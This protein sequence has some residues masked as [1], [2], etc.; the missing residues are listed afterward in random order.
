MNTSQPT[1]PDRKNPYQSPQTTDGYGAEAAE[2]GIWHATD[3]K[4][5]ML[6]RLVVTWEKLRVPY[7]LVLI[8]VVLA[9]TAGAPAWYLPAPY[10]FWHLCF[11]SVI[12]NV[13]FLAGPAV[14][15]YLSWF[16]LRHPAVTTL[17]FLAGT[18]LAAFFAVASLAFVPF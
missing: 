13:C 10:F 11:G 14:D 12:A 7:N 1:G 16:V 9:M 18:G 4:Y 5:M 2:K 6:G 8:L 17:L 3:A 15:G